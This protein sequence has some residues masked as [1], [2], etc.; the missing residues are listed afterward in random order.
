MTLEMVSNSDLVQL[1]PLVSLDWSGSIAFQTVTPKNTPS[2]FSN[3][4]QTCRTWRF[5]HRF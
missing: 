4:E 5:L 1:T 2:G 3:I